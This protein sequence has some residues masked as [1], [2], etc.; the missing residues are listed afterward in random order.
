MKK[1]IIPIAIIALSLSVVVFAQAE[2]LNLNQISEAACMVSAGND[3]VLNIGS[4]TCVKE[5]DKYFYILT[6]GHVVENYKTVTVEFFKA[7]YKARGIRGEVIWQR[8]AEKTDVDFAIIRVNKSDFGK[9]PPRVIP[10]APKGYRIVS[11]NYIA[12]VGCPSARWAQA[13]E[14][15]V[16]SIYSDRIIFTPPPIGGQSGSGIVVMIKGKDNK[17]YTRIGAVLTWRIEEGQT[18]QGGA[19]PISS[20]YALMENKHVDYKIPAIYKNVSDVSEIVNIADLPDVTNMS[21]WDYYG[22]D[23]YNN[24]DA[25]IF[26]RQPAP[27]SP[28]QCPPGGCPT[29]QPE[30]N[31]RPFN[32]GLSPYDVNPP[33]IGGLW[34]GYE[35]PKEESPSLSDD[36]ELRKLADKYTELQKEKDILEGKIL[37]LDA[38]IQKDKADAEAKIAADKL[39]AEKEAKIEEDKKLESL[40]F[41]GRMK[42]SI[43]GFFGGI[44]AGAG[45]G[46]LI[47]IWNKFVKK[48]VAVG[49]DNIQDYLQKMAT[50][51]WGKEVGDDVR[52]ML[53]GVEAA[54]FG[55]V[56]NYVEDIQAKKKVSKATVKG[57]LASQV[58]KSV[59]SKKPVTVAEVIA[60]VKQASLEIGDDT[61]TTG[62]PNRMEE[63]LNSIKEEEQQTTKKPTI[64]P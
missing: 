43:S 40:G 47:F 52:D 56:E 1:W 59:A 38:K 49:V 12:A 23:Y 4:G 22:S 50:N 15:H 41:F 57:K 27:T 34:P 24:S 64:T 30:D 17:W 36:E 9:Y 14:G 13:W 6:N 48:R 61:V 26:R 51:T 39:A 3:S 8:Y 58:S 42:E 60:A 5:D 16:L 20:L 11:G 62:V 32:D 46:F 45:I 25:G 54:L 44:L 28:G 7:G 37:D 55:V 33:D 31:I 10:L 35:V 19:I 29:P 63:I 21:S 2:P 53:E 18:A